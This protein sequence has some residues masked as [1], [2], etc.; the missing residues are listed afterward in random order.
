MTYLS[1]GYKISS[2]LLPVSLISVPKK[3]PLYFT[4]LTGGFLLILFNKTVN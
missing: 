4:Q 2:L 1:V 3:M